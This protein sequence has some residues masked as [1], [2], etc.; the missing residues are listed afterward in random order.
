MSSG[1][2]RQQAYQLIREKLV[3][4]ELVPGS[5]I[6]EPVLARQ[7]GMSRTPVREAIQQLGVE[8]ILQQVPRFGTVIRMPTRQ[9]LIELYEV[10]EALES[11]AASSAV[12]RVSTSDLELL[13]KICRKMY[14][15]A[16]SLRKSGKNAFDSKM[17]K[18]FLSLDMAFHMVLIHATGNQRIKKILE[19][20]R[21]LSRIFG[22]RRREH[23][24]S[25]VATAYKWHRRILR[26]VKKQDAVAAQALMAGHIRTSRHALL[27]CFDT[28]QTR[29]HQPPSDLRELLTGLEDFDFES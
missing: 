21:I 3:S 17:Q 28:Y 4:G 2:L 18:Q 8:G 16:D 7:L 29:G 20:S 19:E 23:T 25:V 22:Y 1:T 12:R 10:R 27:E 5:Q 24:L 9:E 15:L 6:S 13:E 26:A 14:L 11:F